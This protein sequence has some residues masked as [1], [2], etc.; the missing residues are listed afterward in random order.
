MW[1]DRSKPREQSRGGKVTGGFRRKGLGHNNFLDELRRAADDPL[2][3]T[4]YG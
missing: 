2:A 1:G 3:L 4:R